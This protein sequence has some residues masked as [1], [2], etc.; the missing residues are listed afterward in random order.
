[1]SDVTFNRQRRIFEVFSPDGNVA[2]YFVFP[3]T[4]SDGDALPPLYIHAWKEDV[5][6]K[7][8]GEY[9]AS[10]DNMDFF[11]EGP[12]GYVYKISLQVDVPGGGEPYSW[13]L[14]RHGHTNVG[15]DNNCTQLFVPRV[16]CLT[17]RTLV[18]A[19]KKVVKRWTFHGPT[20]PEQ[21]GRL[22]LK[23][24]FQPARCGEN[25]ENNYPKGS[26]GIFKYMEPQGTGEERKGQPG[27]FQGRQGELSPAFVGMSEIPAASAEKL[28][29]LP[30]L[31]EQA[32]ETTGF[33]GSRKSKPTCCNCGWANV[34]DIDARNSEEKRRHAPDPALRTQ[35]VH[36]GNEMEDSRKRNLNP[37][38]CCFFSQLSQNQA[39]QQG[40]VAAAEA[41]RVSSKVLQF[42]SRKG[43]A[44]Q[45][46]D[47][48]LESLSNSFNVPVVVPE[49]G[50]PVVE[51]PDDDSDDSGTENQDS[52]GTQG[53]E[54]AIQMPLQDRKEV[55]ERKLDLTS[56][57]S[58]TNSFPSHLLGLLTNGSSDLASSKE[59]SPNVTISRPIVTKNYNQKFAFADTRINFMTDIVEK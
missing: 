12:V 32:S 36:G 27:A 19:D 18:G 47:S 25:P 17:E 39:L 33:F 43:F 51:A 42:L 9:N 4:M 26:K 1:M 21:F 11:L 49:V 16:L 46:N 44:V 20:V 22:R 28:T 8:E 41:S 13:K 6:F 14:K 10:T 31:S 23:I 35:V 56:H 54:D 24:S 53:S 38:W 57:V 15:R 45:A 48:M 55:H 58:I 30:N 59:T 37:R 40:Q 7:F 3:A 29:P 52:V 34:D 50:H 5:L 2:T